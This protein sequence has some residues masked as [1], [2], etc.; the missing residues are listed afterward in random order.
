MNIRV[1]SDLAGLA[2]RL[3]A[4]GGTLRPAVA[5]GAAAVKR[6]LEDFY[7][8]MPGKSF[9]RDAVAGNKVAVAEIRDSSATVTID[10]RELAHHIRGGTVRPIPPRKALA[11]PV[12]DEARAAGYPSNNRIPGVFHPKG[13]R[14]LAVKN[15][16]S[17][18][19]RVLWVL[20]AS[21]THRPHPEAQP[22][23]ARLASAA[24]P[25]MREAILRALKRR[26]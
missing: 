13:T 12:T 9:Y 24:E 26:G 16:G 15:A 18:S 8:A 14:V 20:A 19:F 22:D 21:V 25:V 11:I 4:A 5:A 7:R 23:E 6:A 3:T 2:A 17:E 1:S 10:S